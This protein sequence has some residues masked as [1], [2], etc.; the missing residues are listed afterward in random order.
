MPQKKTVVNQKTCIG[1]S[2][3][4]SLC[5]S[6]YE[7]KLQPDGTELAEVIS[8]DATEALL[9]ETIITC[10]VGAISWKK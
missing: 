2:M 8:N 6:V 5:P 9:E 10:P 3:C 7:L 1:C 4:V